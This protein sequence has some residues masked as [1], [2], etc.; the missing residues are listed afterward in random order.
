M[1]ATI[2]VGLLLLALWAAAP[3]LAA[4][5]AAAPVNLGE[6][7]SRFGQEHPLAGRLY[8]PATGSFVL[9]EAMLG[10]L[11]QA[12]FVLV[13]ERH[14]NPDHHRLQAWL[15]ESLIAGGRRPAVVFEMIATDRHETIA[16]HLAARPN[17][18]AGLGATL[19]WERNGWPAWSFYQP[20]AAAAIGAGLP[21]VGGGLPR[22]VQRQVSAGGVASL[23]PGFVERLGLARQLDP[24][25][26]RS[27]REELAA[28]HCGML[29]A[30]ALDRMGEVQ[31][32]LDAQMA[33][34]LVRAATGPG[35]DGG[36]LIAGTGHTRRDRAVPWHLGRFV[37]ESK[38]VAIGLVEVDDDTP[39]PI[40]YRDRFGG[41]LPFDYVWFTAR[42]TNENPCD[43][44]A[45]QLRQMTPQGR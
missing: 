44:F 15:V 40:G 2:R 31:R 34:S 17:D 22:T 25:A 26:A 39:S 4:A 23:E 3:F 30:T 10:E 6:W 36:V 43:A 9:P 41:D 24:A 45:E 7:Q 20:I 29:P 18:V 11:R 16:A 32:A 42:V 37:P 35:I 14:D 8:M 27:L 13:G 38:A 1:T 12:R 5:Q 19:D 21:I 28:G 33:D